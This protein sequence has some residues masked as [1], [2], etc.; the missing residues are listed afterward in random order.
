MDPASVVVK[1]DMKISLTAT[2][3]KLVK[4]RFPGRTKSAAAGAEDLVLLRWR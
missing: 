2:A 4:L 1:D 3:S